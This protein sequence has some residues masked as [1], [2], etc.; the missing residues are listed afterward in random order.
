MT[1]G[2]PLASLSLD[3]D[4]LWTYLRTRGDPGW[5]TAPSYLPTFVPL[6]LDL[7]DRLKLRITVF[8]VG[9]DAARPANLPYLQAIADRGHEIGNHS[10]SHEC[11]LH[12]HSHAELEAEVVRAEEAITEAT[13]Q[14]PT[15]FRGPGF[16]WS[17]E[18]LEILNRRGYLYDASTLPT[19]LGP[20]A[21]WYF[22]ARSGLAQ[23][24]RNRRGALFGTFHDGFRPIRPYLWHLQDRGQLL[25]IPITTFPLIRLPFHLS[26]LLY[27]GG[28]SRGLML[29]YVRGA[30]TMCRAMGIEPSFLLHPPDF[31]GAE[32]APG[33]SFF[34]GMSLPGQTKR[35]IAVQVLEILRESFRLVPMGQHAGSILAAGRL[36]ERIPAFA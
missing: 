3:L 34:P 32:Q 6:M 14:R 16:S 28:I 22:L 13:G 30:L 26:Y 2:K 25:E 1:S 21:R 31:L 20:L 4:D 12:L 17:P 10:F 9:A 7:L 29:A 18:L 11:W 35:D 27:L 24:E 8:M 36:P 19:F 23:E 15:G 33:L 5:E